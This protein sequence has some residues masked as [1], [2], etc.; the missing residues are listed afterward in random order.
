MGAHWSPMVLQRRFW[1]LI[2]EGYSADDAA[3]AV[4][5]SG[6]TGRSWIRQRGGV[7][8]GLRGPAGQL[9]PRLTPLERDEISIGTAC[10]ES[11]R[12]I[13]GRLNRAPSTIMREIVNNGR[14][15]EAMGRY[16]AL[17][18]FGGNRGGWDAKSG[19][20]ASIAQVRS[21]ARARRPKAGKLDR[22]PELREAVEKLLHQKY[23]PEQIAG[24]LPKMYPDRPEMRVSHETIYKYVYVQGRGELRRELATCLRTGR[25]LRKPR[26]RTRAN[27]PQGRIAGMINIAERP[28]EAE[29]RAVAGHWEGDLIIGKNQAS[30]IGT[31]VERSSGFVQLLHL[32]QTRSADVVAAEIIKTIGPARGT[33]PN[34]DLGSGQGDDPARPYQ[35]R[36]RHRHLLLRP[37]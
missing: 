20:R 15:H 4:G 28:P 14:V 3:D 6:G 29:D 12:S 5:V 18:R 11:E 26:N 35:R 25:A 36:R 16:R 27:G 2:G 34:A 30:Q 13:A 10:G 32:P 21:E 33:T 19:Y 22:N 23:S 37:A 24:R 31:L 1:E 17:H 9:R 7:N 8:P